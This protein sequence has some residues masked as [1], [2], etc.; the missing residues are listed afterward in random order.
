MKK[1]LKREIYGD[2]IVGKAK[3]KVDMN[4]CGDPRECR[5]CVGLCPH[6]VLNL[7]FSDKDFHDPQDWIIYDAFPHLCKKDITC[8]L[9]VEKCPNKAISIKK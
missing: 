9:C 1:Y 7:I 5:I 8:N 4:K 2:G 3:I 6:G